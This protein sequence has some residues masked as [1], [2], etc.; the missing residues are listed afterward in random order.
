VNCRKAAGSEDLRSISNPTWKIQGTID[1]P[2]SLDKVETAVLAASL[3]T[4]DR[5]AHA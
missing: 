4:I 2:S 1:I 3:E 5:S